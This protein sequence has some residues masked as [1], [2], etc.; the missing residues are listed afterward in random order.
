MK[1][2]SYAY[3]MGASV[4]SKSAAAGEFESDDLA[5]AVGMVGVD[6]RV[7]PGDIMLLMDM[8]SRYLVASVS[9]SWDG[10]ITAM[11]VPEEV[12][13]SRKVASALSLQLLMMH[14]TLGNDTVH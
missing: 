6:K 12:K 7:R 14:P 5:G 4:S 8:Q 11:P 3:R 9:K 10:A 1:I 2:W 13:F